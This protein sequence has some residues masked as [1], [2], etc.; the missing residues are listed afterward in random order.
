[1]ESEE[2]E[3]IEAGLGSRSNLQ[4]V[5]N[6]S[7][8]RGIGGVKMQLDICC[9]IIEEATESVCQMVTAVSQRKRLLKR[10]K[11]PLREESAAKEEEH[12]KKVEGLR[13]DSEEKREKER[14][15]KDKE[16]RKEEQIKGRRC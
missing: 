6:A 3:K 14:S 16:E 2:E 1:V 5:M 8:L 10:S 7:W 13:V 12:R 9:A 4:K 15:E 11:G